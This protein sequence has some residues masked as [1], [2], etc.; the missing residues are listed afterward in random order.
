MGDVHKRLSAKLARVDDLD[1]KEAKL[2]EIAETLGVD[3]GA[4]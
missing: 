4:L 2:R 1:A 3:I